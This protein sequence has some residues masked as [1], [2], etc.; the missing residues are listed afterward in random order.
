MFRWY[1]CA[2]VCYVYLSDVPGGD[3]VVEDLANSRWFTRGWTLQELLSPQA[4]LFFAQDWT[5]LGYICPHPYDHLLD[6]E[7]GKKETA[8]FPELLNFTT[9]VSRITQI[10]EEFIL[11][12]KRLEQACVSQRMFWASRR[13]TTRPEDRAYSLM[14]LFDISMPILYGEGL[15]KAFRR[16]QEEIFSSTTDQ[17]LLA[18]YNSGMTTYRLLADS[19]AC[20]KNSGKVRRLH[21]RNALALEAESTRSAFYLTNIGLRIT[22]PVYAAM[23]STS[24]SGSRNRVKAKLDCY[25]DHDDGIRRQIGLDLAYLDTDIKGRVIYICQ[26]LDSWTF[27]NCEGIPT[28]IFIRGIGYEESNVEQK[29]PSI[30]DDVLHPEDV[31]PRSL[32]IIA[33]CSCVPLEE[34]KGGMTFDELGFD[35]LLLIEIIHLLSKET[36][37]SIGR[38]DFMAHPTIEGFVA[39]LCSKVKEKK[40]LEKDEPCAI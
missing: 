39:F 8:A 9:P 4:L 12:S 7:S 31:R 32:G 36:G 33:K 26:R 35:S 19:P 16:L 10:P 14:G 11:G 1:R 24:T 6:H 5:P 15:E 18:W 29:A 40:S 25:V 21:E 13:T 22:L 38:W 17:S 23:Q 3:N 27:S 2:R 28:S 37:V 34:L 20:F 30:S